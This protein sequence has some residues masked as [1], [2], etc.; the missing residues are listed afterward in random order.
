MKMTIKTIILNI[1]SWLGGS[2]VTQIC[3]NIKQTM[4]CSSVNKFN[5]D[6]YMSTKQENMAIITL[7]YICVR[8]SC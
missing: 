7:N 2:L 6:I 4:P 3:W 5:N 8:D 1:F